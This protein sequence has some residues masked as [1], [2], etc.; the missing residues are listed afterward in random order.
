M[1][2]LKAALLTKLKCIGCQGTLVPIHQLHNLQQEM[3]ALC[4]SGRLDNHFIHKY[5]SGF[6]YDYLAIL[7]KAQSVIIIAIPQPITK[8]RFVWRGKEREMI[9]PPTYIY[10]EDE[11][12]VLQI[13][14]SEL[15]Q[16][17]FSLVRAKIPLKLLSVKSGLSRYG[18]NHISYI[19]G[20]GS[21]YRLIALISDLPS[22]LNVQRDIQRM[23]CCIHCSA[24]LN[25][26]PTK[27]MDIHSDMIR[28]TRCLTCINE[29]A[30][31]FP[32]W[33]DC[34]WHNSLIG[35]MQC[36]LAC[37]QN[38]DYILTRHVEDVLTETEVAVFLNA[39]DF[40]RLSQTTRDTL[41][42]LNLT[43][44]SLTILQRNLSALL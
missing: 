32:D 4:Q 41:R 11:K 3:T 15:Q 44:Y 28:A 26:C 39:T 40:T 38:R 35:C 21:F 1:E 2:A 14:K 24:C 43:D 25:S 6:Q 31:P 8:L 9:V 20:M 37:P 33:I 12:R 30:E 16:E 7:P 17:G 13:A 27:C 34:N 36:Q 42:R 18:R 5:L 22:D 29:S 23:S 19:D 10:A